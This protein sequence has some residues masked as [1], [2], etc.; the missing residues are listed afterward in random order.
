MQVA[1]T[2]AGAMELR[3]GDARVT[4]AAFGG[5]QLRLVTAMLLL[6][7]GAP[8]T[9]DRVAEEI[10][11]TGPPATWRSALRTLVSR[12]RRLLVDVGLPDDVVANRA[13]RFVVDLPELVIDI[14]LAVVEARRAARHL[15]AGEMGLAR[16]I[17][18]QSLAVLALPVLAGLDAPWV[19]R[20]RDRLRDHHVDVLL[21]LS[22]AERRRARWS[23][24][25]RHATRALE[26]APL[27]EAAWRALMR[28]E[29]WAGNTGA[30]LA[31]Y[32]RCRD[33]LGQDLGTDPDERTQRLHASILR[34]AP[35]ASSLGGPFAPAR[36]GPSPTSRD[37]DRRGL[38]QAPAHPTLVGRDHLLDEVVG[39]LAD[40][41]SLLVR[42]PAGIGKTRLVFAALATS[43]LSGRAVDRLL[44]S[45]GTSG[46]HLATLAPIARG[47]P[48]DRGVLSDVYGWF[49]RRWRERVDR[50][51]PALVW[52]DD[53]PHC[54]D[55]SA[56][57]LRHAATGGAIQLVV[58]QRLPEPLGDDLLALATE[59]LLRPVDVGPL[60]DPDA[61][62][63]ARRV[64]A[65][66][67]P[68]AGLDRLL[69]LAAGNPLYVRELARSVSPGDRV[70]HLD[71]TEDLVA[72]PLR[73]LADSRR[74][75]AELIAL[76]E[77]VL[78]DLFAPRADD[79][80]VL[81][82]RGLI[83][84]HGER[85]LCIDH[86]LRS[87]WLVHR[88]GPMPTDSYRDL[89][90]L[91]EVTGV[92]SHLDPVTRLDWELQ[93][94]RR[95]DSTR[96]RDAT[97]MAISRSDGTT[98]LRLAEAVHGPAR[99][100]LRG[101]ARVLS[102]ELDDGLVLLEQVRR[103][104]PVAQRVEAASWL[105][106]FVGVMQ[107]DFTR[108][109]RLLSATDD[110]SLAPHHRRR[111]LA[112]RLWLWIYGP[113][114]SDEIEDL[115]G[116]ADAGPFDPSVH[117]VLVAGLCILYQSASPWD[118]QDTLA[119]IHRVE[120]EHDIGPAALTRSRAVECGF[121]LQAGRLDR[122]FTVAVEHL[123]EV[124]DHGVP[125]SLTLLGGMGAF[126][127][128]LH[129]HLDV[130]ISMGERA[131]RP[132]GRPDWFNQELLAL[133]ILLGNRCYRGGPG[134]TLSRLVELE[135]RLDPT[136]DLVPLWAARARVLAQGA[137]GGP[138]DHDGLTTA[139]TLM[140]SHGKHGWEIALA[141]EV[142]DRHGPRALHELVV[143]D[144]H[145]IDGPGL[146]AIAVAAAHA[147]LDQDPFRLSAAG[148][149]YELAGMPA[150]ASRAFADVVA[151]VGPDDA[152]GHRARC[153]IVRSWRTWD[154]HDTWWTADVP[155]LP[156]LDLVRR[157]WP[158]H[159][160][161]ATD[162][163]ALEVMGVSEA[164]TAVAAILDL[165]F[166]RVSQLKPRRPPPSW[167][168]GT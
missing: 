62:Q 149:D 11:P 110:P 17:G 5:R 120:A 80:G 87:A 118:L 166:T 130:A 16:N 90:H 59:G 99:D 132:S 3:R 147:R 107:G 157:A 105:A 58:T 154:G 101:Q 133:L 113:S 129:G 126:V 61:A 114:T 4:D 15:R 18:R 127:A 68:P 26:L 83:R 111:L 131:V 98:A 44:A 14:E 151:W 136:F 95:P 72:R 70:L 162:D 91:A 47:A 123:P 19:D 94:G 135:T 27:R 89:L 163:H 45:T 153:G 46:I 85:E 146:A 63:L 141:A 160:D 29:S 134:D 100:L 159:G 168:P 152:T 57:I 155:G 158:R 82:R 71:T 67:L 10:W 37:V 64:A 30:A 119:R 109:H 39:L 54:D 22:E 52:L 35:A 24:S 139:L 34:A 55:L 28:T 69:A 140:A 164:V 92:A 51:G 122:A 13:G 108:A 125:E 48:I 97:R 33:R 77:P 142:T 96:A 8:V 21:V 50:R 79:L 104:G 66:A 103:E 56:A 20:V 88:L 23:A 25:R 65:A 150:A 161:D 117:E 38:R 137:A 40:G 115:H 41:A 36:S 93:A 81:L 148:L 143:E 1:L 167:R 60:S 6:E 121:W 49:L 42:G 124:L 53:A 86:P 84:R 73:H 144:G 116:I 9:V 138:I 165:P 7:R 156:T 2:L 74:R 31:A 128:A 12:L 76:A 75:T 102:G 112:G 32:H 43:T 106:R 78:A 145:R